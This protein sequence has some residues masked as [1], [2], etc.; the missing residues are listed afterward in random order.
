MTEARNIG[1]KVSDQLRRMM[2]E[3]DSL[4]TEHGV[5]VAKDEIDQFRFWA[6]WVIKKAER[7]NAS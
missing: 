5:Q 7:K 4:I 3:F 6:L 2:C 1:F